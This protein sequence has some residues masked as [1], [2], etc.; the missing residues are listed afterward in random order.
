M[1]RFPFSRRER[2]TSVYA[3]HRLATEHKFL[4]PPLLSPAPLPALKLYERDKLHE[5]SAILR[6]RRKLPAKPHAK[7]SWWRDEEASLST[8]A[9]EKFSRKK[10]FTQS[11]I[12]ECF[13]SGSNKY[14]SLSFIFLCGD[15]KD[16]FIE[17]SLM[18]MKIVGSVELS[19]CHEIA[20]IFCQHSSTSLQKAEKL[21]Q[22]FP[23]PAAPSTRRNHAKLSMKKRNSGF[24]VLPLCAS[25]GHYKAKCNNFHLPAVS[26]ASR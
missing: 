1:R 25:H 12:D 18:A 17:V 11:R 6:A 14:F 4:H 16:D 7:I 8:K 22:L 23:R 10:S 24:C 3:W 21:R 9:S 13:K 19:E 26:T 15:T 5:S 20:E 2:V